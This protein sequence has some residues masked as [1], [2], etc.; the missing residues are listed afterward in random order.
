MA[1]TSYLSIYLT[2]VVRHKAFF[3]A[4]L[5]W[6]ISAFDLGNKIPVGPTTSPK[7][8]MYIRYRLPLERVF[9]TPSASLSRDIMS[10][11]FWLELP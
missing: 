10:S 6:A 9:D 1:S 11:H 3:D 2:Y 4:R 8:D 5:A 7:N